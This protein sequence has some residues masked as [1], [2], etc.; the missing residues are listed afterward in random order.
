MVEAL[1]E[2]QARVLLDEFWDISI[3]I[4]THT[5]TIHLAWDIPHSAWETVCNSP[6]HPTMANLRR[7]KLGDSYRDEH[8]CLACL[9]KAMQDKREQYEYENDVPA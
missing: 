6:T 7:P 4:S 8:W 3:V 1:R 5:G 2:F 9:R